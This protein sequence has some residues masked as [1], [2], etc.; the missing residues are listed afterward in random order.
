MEKESEELLYKLNQEKLEVYEDRLKILKSRHESL[1]LLNDDMFKLHN[2]VRPFDEDANFIMAEK[3]LYLNSLKDNIIDMELAIESLRVTVHKM[4]QE[5]KDEYDMKLQLAQDNLVKKQRIEQLEAKLKE[6][7][8]E[9][10][11]EKN[12]KKNS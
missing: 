6:A 2:P 3:D 10:E 9:L 11:D 8:I 5:G 7:G 4:S 1:K 12:N